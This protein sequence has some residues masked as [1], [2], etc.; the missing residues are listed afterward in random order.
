VYL[1]VFGFFRVGFICSKISKLQGCLLYGAT[2]HKEIFSHQQ[3]KADH[4]RSFA[5]MLEC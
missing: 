2:R 4:E 3:P 1:G 5:K